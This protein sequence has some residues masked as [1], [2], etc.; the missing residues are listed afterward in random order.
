[1]PRH[2]DE[3]VKGFV[4]VLEGFVTDLDVAMVNLHD[5]VQLHSLTVDI[6]Q[7]K[8]PSEYANA[9]QSPELVNDLESIYN[10]NYVS[11]CQRVVQAN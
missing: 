6:S 1:M 5:S 9:L 3:S 2:K 10:T 8:K 4:K 7:Y 11:S